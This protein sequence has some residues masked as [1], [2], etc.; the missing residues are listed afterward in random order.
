[1]K[2][3]EVGKREGNKF[4][5]AKM[6]SSQCPEILKQLNAGEGLIVAEVEAE[7]HCS[8]FFPTSSSVSPFVQP[9]T[10]LGEDV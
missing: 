4:K 6:T 10:G 8:L 3:A 7:C 1:M 5:L 9:V 2:A